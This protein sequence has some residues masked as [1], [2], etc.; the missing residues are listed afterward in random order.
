MIPGAKPGV[1]VEAR[2]LVVENDVDTA[3][4]TARLLRLFGCEVHI[5]LDGPQAL[6]TAQRWRPEFILLDIG[7]PE[8]DGFEVARR[9]RQEAWCRETPLIAVTGHGQQEDR[10][11]SRAA[12]IDH[13]LLKPVEPGELLALLSGSEAMSGAEGS[14]E[15]VESSAAVAW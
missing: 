6:A 10:Q 5:A 12:G 15:E 8:M 1:R 9:L 14:P 11:R 4:S 2:V 13:H 3:E 7:L